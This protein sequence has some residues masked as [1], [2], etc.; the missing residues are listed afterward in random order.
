MTKK[1]ME[2]NEGGEKE[3]FEDWEK[4][5]FGNYRFWEIDNVDRLTRRE[6]REVVEY[7]RKGKEEQN[8]ITNLAFLCVEE[9]V[10]MVSYEDPSLRVRIKRGTK[11]AN[12]IKILVSE[13]EELTMKKK[14]M[15][16]ERQMYE[17]RINKIEKE[18]ESLLDEI[19]KLL[20]DWREKDTGSR[21]D[22]GKKET[23]TQT[24]LQESGSLVTEQEE[25]GEDRSSSDL[26][27]KLMELTRR[28]RSLEERGPNPRVER[29]QEKT[30]TSVI[31]RK[32]KRITSKSVSRNRVRNKEQEKRTEERDKRTEDQNERRNP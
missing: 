13:L 28:V 23:S 10:N 31:G 32:K 2:K 4:P 7:I 14:D 8:D 12:I 3:W 22:I 21:K 25:T 27:R 11:C 1:M 9:Y 20:E 29:T 18:N 19:T 15:T 24:Q 16:W 30:W 6:Q 5:E 17:K 26:E